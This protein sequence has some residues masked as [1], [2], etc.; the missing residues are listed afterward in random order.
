MSQTRNLRIYSPSIEVRLLS[1]RVEQILLR[2]IEESS[3]LKLQNINE[4]FTILL[5][6]ESFVDLVYEFLIKSPQINILISRLYQDQ[7]E[8]STM[9]FSE[10]LSLQ[11]KLFVSWICYSHLPSNETDF[12][13]SSTK[14]IDPEHPTWKDYY[15]S[16]ERLPSII[17]YSLAEKILFIGESV[18]ILNRTKKMTNDFVLWIQK[19]VLEIFESYKGDHISSPNNALEWNS[20][21]AMSK[22][23]KL[24]KRISEALYSL[25]IDDYHLYSHLNLIHNLFFFKEGFAHRKFIESCDSLMTEKDLNALFQDSVLP[26]MSDDLIVNVFININ[27][28]CRPNNEKNRSLD[29]VCLVYTPTWPLNLFFDALTINKYESIFK[30]LFKVKRLQ[31]Y[32]HNIWKKMMTYS[33]KFGS[34]IPIYI[35]I[36]FFW[37]KLNRFFDT[38]DSY[39]RVDVIISELQ[40]YESK[41]YDVYNFE[42]LKKL[43]SEFMERISDLCFIE[44]N[45]FTETLNKLFTICDSFTQWARG[46]IDINTFNTEEYKNIISKCKHSFTEWDNQYQLFYTLLSS[47]PK[48]S[49]LLLLLDEIKEVPPVQYVETYNVVNIPKPEKKFSTSKPSGETNKKRTS[50]QSTMSEDEESK[51][52]KSKGPPPKLLERLMNKTRKFK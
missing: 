4:L 47:T 27:I 21:Q 5:E 51:P 9:L 23:V 50:S 26:Y 14:A 39:L 7:S 32:L 17:S 41:F 24:E 25:F 20:T 29:D 12:W 11:R 44:S 45:V 1:S 42:E 37:I 2:K 15:V 40:L 10:W 30:L 33:G 6:Y 3:K 48:Y 8:S 52:K 36:N 18:G 16:E 43:Y 34:M 19:K 13:I 46:D 35:D 38:L 31:F 28:V 49:K 22:V